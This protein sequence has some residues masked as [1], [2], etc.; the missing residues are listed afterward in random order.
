MSSLDKINKML[1]DFVN[2]KVYFEDKSRINLFDYTDSLKK[3]LYE[4][5]P[6]IYARKYK[7]KMSVKESIKKAREFFEYLG[8]DYVE[9][10]DMRLNDGTITFETEDEAKKLGH[11]VNSASGVDEN[12]K[13]YIRII[14]EEN[15]TDVYTIIHE[16]LHDTNLIIVDKDEV[17]LDEYYIMENRDT[18]TELISI[19]GTLIARNYFKSHNE[20]E[21]DIDVMNEL[22]AISIKCDQLD[23]AVNMVNLFIEKGCITR[24]DLVE[25]MEGKD[26]IAGDAIK[27]YIE[28]ITREEDL[29]IYYNERY[30]TGFVLALYIINKYDNPE[31]VLKE[32]N[33]MITTSYIEDIFDY[34]DLDCHFDDDNML[35][36]FNEETKKM[37]TKTVKQQMK[38]I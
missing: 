32:L 35:V 28:D 1:Y 21:Y 27:D 20:K 31:E 22:Y 12:K 25:L 4:N 10:F 6:Y 15:F 16:V 19:L 11:D 36:D 18:F 8:Q 24:Y 29:L 7:K 26:E 3:I 13:R 2:E 14:Y 34:L 30:L 9:Y 17:T 38:K 37:L 23:F 5:M 33:E